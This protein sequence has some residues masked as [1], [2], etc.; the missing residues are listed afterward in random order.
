MVKPTR[1][2]L[3]LQGFGT[4]GRFPHDGYQ[5]AEETGKMIKKEKPR[6][7]RKITR[8]DLCANSQIYF[9]LQLQRHVYVTYERKSI[10]A[11]YQI[12]VKYVILS[13]SLNIYSFIHVF[14]LTGSQAF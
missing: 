3:S 9:L 8:S 10:S 14:A 12:V 6:D 1:R 5:R 4:F 11:F 7:K 13:P 2:L